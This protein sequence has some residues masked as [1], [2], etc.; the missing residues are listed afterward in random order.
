LLLM[1]VSL[2][3]L[4]FLPNATRPANLRMPAVPASFSGPVVLDP[5]H[6]GNDS[7]AMC[8][9]FLEKDLTLDLAKRVERLVHQEGFATILTRNDDHFMSLVSR[10]A[11]ANRQPNSIFVSIHFNDG[12]REASNGIETYY[13]SRQAEHDVVSWL[14]FLQTTALAS[15]NFLSQSLA[16]FIQDALVLRTQAANRGTKTEQFYV[17]TNVR[18]PAVLVEG[19][20]LTN[21]DDVTRLSSSEYREQ[22]AAAICEGIVHYRDALRHSQPALATGTSG[23]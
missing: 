17:I 20:F 4:Q 21:K 9:G 13:A 19:G 14:P 22:M 18:H 11:V 12:R 1:L 3:C 23:G 6:G 10:V 7:G 5:G 15:P 8:E 2:I 16:G